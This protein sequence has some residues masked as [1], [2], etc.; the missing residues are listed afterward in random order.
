MNCRSAQQLLSAQRDGALAPHERVALEGHLG[1]CAECR[2]ASATVAAAIEG[3]RATAAAVKIPDAERAWQ[4]IHREIRKTQPIESRSPLSRWMLPLGAAAA[5]TVVAA[6]FLPRANEPAPAVA[7]VDPARAEFV[8]VADGAS[9][10]VY[11]DGESGWVVV[12]AV[13]NPRPTRL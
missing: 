7:R 12:W 9:S 5:L 2:R 8:E 3:W 4:D 11:V 10:V 1:G 6:I 13:D